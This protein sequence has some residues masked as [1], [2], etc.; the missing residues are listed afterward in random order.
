MS[1]SEYFLKNGLI[2]NIIVLKIIIKRIL[3]LIIKTDYCY[4][5]V[6][7]NKSRRVQVFWKREK[8]IYIYKMVKNIFIIIYA[9][10][11]AIIREPWQVPWKGRPF[12][13]SRASGSINNRLT[14][15]SGHV[16]SRRRV[17]TVSTSKVQW[18]AYL[19][20]FGHIL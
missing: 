6:E 16:L 1:K 5:F 10:I 18:M 2:P 14:V 17:K 3:N 19:G 4:M 11:Q 20:D 8:K 15:R 12:G 9:K 7:V 13:G